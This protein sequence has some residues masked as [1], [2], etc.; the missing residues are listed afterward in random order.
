M[1]LFAPRSY[2]AV[3]FDL[4]GTLISSLPVVDRAWATVFAE[5]S[6]P[7]GARVQ[8][9]V[10]ARAM[11]AD[12]LGDRSQE[13]QEAA[14]ARVVGIEEHD[15]DGLTLLP[16][17][18]AALRSLAGSARCAIVTSCT[19][20]LAGVRLRATGLP[21]PDALVTADDVT[22]GKPHPAAYAAGA[23]ALGVAAAACLVVED[24]PAGIAAGHAAGADVLAVTTTHDPAALDAE[25]VVPDLASVRFVP[26]VAGVRLEPA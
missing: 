25:I 15:T 20:G 18:E 5:F 26:G 14:F 8:H 13:E 4:D 10:P 2:A 12:Y 16:G 9:G 23:A 17:A 19:R 21:T 7:A 1:T 24:A 11:I 22:H 3:L 6:F